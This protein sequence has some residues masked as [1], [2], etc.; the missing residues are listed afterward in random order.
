MG[1][2]RFGGADGF[3]LVGRELAADYADKRGSGGVG[4]GVLAVRLDCIDWP[5]IARNGANGLVRAKWVLV[6][7]A[8]IF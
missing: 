5:R 2:R 3:G 1:G 7:R 4:A 6:L 8:L